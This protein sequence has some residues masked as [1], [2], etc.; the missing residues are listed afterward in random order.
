M[1]V[2]F[3]FFFFL[4]ISFLILFCHGVQEGK[5]SCSDVGSA[6]LRGSLKVPLLSDN[7]SEGVDNSSPGIVPV[8]L[9]PEDK[10]GSVLLDE[11]DQ[12]VVREPDISSSRDVDVDAGESWI[13]DPVVNLE[14][15]Y[16]VA[17]LSTGGELEVGTVLAG[18]LLCP[19]GDHEFI[20]GRWFRWRP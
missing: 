1:I 5:E 4:I 19:C 3:F 18:V 15:V 12:L 10:K 17:E 2:F 13:A 16:P 8:F 11:V 7:L 20:G 14:P 9:L 6:I